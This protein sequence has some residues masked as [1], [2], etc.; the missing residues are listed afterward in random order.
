M[1]KNFLFA[2]MSAIVLTGAVS[3]SACSSSDEVINNPD[4]NPETKSVKAE[5]AL[6]INHP[7]N[8]TRMTEANTQS[9]GSFLGMNNMFLFSLAGAPADESNFV[10][11]GKFDLGTLT[12]SEISSTKSSKV[13]TLYIPTTTSNFLFYGKNAITGNASSKGS[14]TFNVSTA[15][16]HPNEIFFNLNPIVA[17]GDVS[18]NVTSKETILAGYMNTIE[19]TTNWANSVSLAASDPAFTGLK[20]AYQTFTSLT[21]RQGSSVSILRQV[22]DL[23][24]VA[25]EISAST[26]GDVKT[27]ADAI[28]SNI[29][30]EN[31]GFSVVS[32]SGTAAVLQFTSTDDIV[33]NFPEQIGLPA[34]SAVLKYTSTETI[35]SRFSYAGFKSSA[36]FGETPSTDM[37]NINTPAEIVYYDNSPLRVSNKAVAVSGYPTTPNNWEDNSSWTTEAGWGGTSVGADTRAVAMQYNIKYGVALFK[38]NAK[39]GSGVTALTDNRKA[40]TNNV[41]ENQTDISPANLKLTGII[42]GGQP[43]QANWEFLPSSGTAFNQTVYDPITATGLSTNDITNYTLL[44]DNYQSTAASVYVVLE[45]LNDDK[46]FYGKDGLIAKGQKFYLVGELNPEGSSTLTW[47][48]GIPQNG[49][50]RVFIQDFLTTANFTIDNG[51]T[52]TPTRN[53]SLQNAYSVIPDLR[54]TQMT[55]GLSVDLTWKP[56]LTFNV[57]L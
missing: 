40:R 33:K 24:R 34:G 3:F 2:I 1:K 5:L 48:A 42:I 50:N 47:P 18:S 41:E 11:L 16:N 53:P 43:S 4:Y 27:I 32:G 6:S 20:N 31:K 37:G 14:L 9:N 56:G 7:A 28:I 51:S 35:G 29:T 54:S 17:D 57:P 12:S 36:L 39:L 21:L 23:Y 8:R 44:L 19:N 55:F 38:A 49:N 10:N 13:Y 52:E 15:L 30:G 45:F 22:Q 25:A 46:D 26:T